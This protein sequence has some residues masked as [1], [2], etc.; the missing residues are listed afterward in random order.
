MSEEGF[1]FLCYSAK[2][3]YDLILISVR[4]SRLQ[5]FTG[6]TES[7]LDCKSPRKSEY[8]SRNSEC[9]ILSESWVSNGSPVNFL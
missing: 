7:G 9:V 1:F 3:L 8:W 6:V 2:A 4:F 5:I